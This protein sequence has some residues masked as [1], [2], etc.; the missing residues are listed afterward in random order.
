MQKQLQIRAALIVLTTAFFALLC[1]AASAAGTHLSPADLY[2]R[3][4]QILKEQFYDT[5]FNGQDWDAWRDKYAGHLS[6]KTEAYAAINEMVSSLGDPYTRFLTPEIMAKEQP[7]YP[8]QGIGIGVQIRLNEA[9]KPVVVAVRE[10]SPAAEAGLR[11]G[12]VISRINGSSVSGMSADETSNKIRGTEG[13]KLQVSVL[14]DGREL[15]FEMARRIPMVAQVDTALLPGNLAYIKLGNVPDSTEFKR[16]IIKFAEA[17]GLILDVRDTD[18]SFIKSYWE[19]GDMLVR[20]GKT[21]GLSVHGSIEYR[22]ANGALKYEKPIVVLINGS[23]VCSGEALAAALHESANAKLVGSKTYGKGLLQAQESIDDEHK[24]EISLGSQLTPSG[25]AIEK[26]G[27]KPD[28]EIPLDQDEQQFMGPWWSAAVVGKPQSPFTGVDLQLLKA[29]RV[30][31]NVVSQA[32]GLPLRVDDDAA[33]K[34]RVVKYVNFVRPTTVTGGRPTT[35]PERPIA[36]KWALVVGISKFQNPSIN[37]KY[38]KK[39]AEDFATYLVSDAK[40]SADH[41][42]LLTDERATRSTILSELGD[43][44]LPRVVRPDDLVVIYFSTHGSPAALDIGGVNY[45]LAHDTDAEGLYASGIAMED[46]MRIIKARIHSDRVV[47]VLDACHSGVATAEGKGLARP[48]NVDAS[49]IAQGTGQLVISSSE[50]DQVSWESKRYPNSVFTRCLIQALKK[51]GPN[52][53]LG[54]AFSSMKNMV[55]NEVQQD[56][57]QQQVPILKSKWEGA[58]LRI[59]APPAAPHSSV[60]LTR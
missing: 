38:A 30:L 34:G 20:R 41:V 45:I 25:K 55:E 42:K 57:G 8:R 28:Y 49:A 27:I 35:G 3:T 60:L 59:S 18:N 4:W 14:R 11:G 44:W 19:I 43:K 1:L 6:T 26:H 33:V 56:R 22:Q 10:E 58:G 2:A 46:L 52:I 50:P 39:D 47:L 37:L 21:F 7:A 51:G 13:S 54:D 9:Q 24:L 15:T 31:E 16:Q 23:T 36:D 29:I 32:K 17:D 12:D 48:A 5:E 40:F 53:T